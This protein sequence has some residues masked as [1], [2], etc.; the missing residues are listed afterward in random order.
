[1]LSEGGKTENRYIILI[2]TLGPVHTPYSRITGNFVYA[3]NDVGLDISPKFDGWSR[4][5]QAPPKNTN[6]IKPSPRL[7]QSLT[8]KRG[9]VI[10]FR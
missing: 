10:F 3:S 5:W 6:G 9:S 7:L 1:M 4:E 8:E 2:N